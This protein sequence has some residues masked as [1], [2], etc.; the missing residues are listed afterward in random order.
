MKRGKKDYLAADERRFG[1]NLEEWH[2]TGVWQY[3]DGYKPQ[4][5]VIEDDGGDISKAGRVSMD[6]KGL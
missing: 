2:E 4:K 3:R 6:A 5:A 1:G